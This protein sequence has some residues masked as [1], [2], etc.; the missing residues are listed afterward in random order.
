LADKLNAEWPLDTLVQNY[1]ISCRPAQRPAAVHRELVTRRRLPRQQ[2]AEPAE[3]AENNS[4]LAAVST[5]SA[6]IVVIT[7]RRCRDPVTIR[8]WLAESA[9]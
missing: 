5:S 3:R 8:A 7:R 9:F 6:L 1:W 2:N 4:Y